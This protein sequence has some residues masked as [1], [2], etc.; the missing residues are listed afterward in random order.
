MPATLI[1]GVPGVGK[2]RLLIDLML[3][4]P[5]R[6]AGF[7]TEEVRDDVQRVGFKV[8]TIPGGTVAMLADTRWVDK[9]FRVGS[10]GV[11]EDVIDSVLVPMIEVVVEK[12]RPLVI[13]EIGKMQVHSARFRDAVRAAFAS[14]IPIVATV[15]IERD[16]FVASLVERRDA[17]L[18]TV[19][20]ANRI[21]MRGELAWHL[22]DF[23]PVP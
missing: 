9:P 10:Y 16:A 13:D 22:R 6:L 5:G 8:R 2:S 20:P 4:H 14:G 7:V 21:A 18:F 1:T 3:A 19:T 15:P 23:L 11:D 17:Q 12:R